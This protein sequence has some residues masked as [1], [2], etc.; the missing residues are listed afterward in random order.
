MGKKGPNGSAEKGFEEPGPND[1]Q[2][3]QATHRQGGLSITYVDLFRV[4]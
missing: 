4:F 1:A 3:I 2:V